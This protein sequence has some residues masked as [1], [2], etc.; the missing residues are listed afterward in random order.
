MEYRVF[1]VLATELAITVYPFIHE[2]VNRYDVI[3]FS[4]VVKK[5]VAK[6]WAKGGQ[7]GQKLI[8][9]KR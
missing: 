4:Y 3:F 8:S 7:T 5:Q 9:L 6:G 2:R 1:A